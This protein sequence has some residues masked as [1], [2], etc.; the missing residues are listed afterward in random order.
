MKSSL[1]IGTRS[2][3]LALWQ[4]EF[5]RAELHARFPHLQIELYPIKTTGDKLLN[6]PLSKIGDKGLFTRDIEQ[7]LL[8]GEIDLA[9]HSLKDLPTQLPDG[10]TIAAVTAREATHDVLI[11]NA[12]YTIDTLP[13]A[14]CVATGSL[15]RRAQLLARRPD[16]RIAEMRGNLHTRLRKFDECN[17]L[18]LHHPAHLDAMVL[19]FAGVHRLGLDHRISEHISL[20]LLLPAVGQGTL[21][22]ETRHDDSETLALVRPLN[23]MPTFLCITAERSFL[24]YLEGGCQIPI[25]ALAT[26]QGATLSLSAF[27]GALNGQP[28][29][30]NQLSEVGFLEPLSSQVARAEALGVHLAEQMLAA[31]GRE[32]L[33]SIR[34][35]SSQH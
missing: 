4:A 17:A 2:S 15:R 9:V 35:S 20:N 8:S 7:A 13:P 3:P 11:S 23:D 12:G 25:G 19:A 33:S 24:R 34:A 27:I 1:L 16:L 29:V 32:I 26:L 6:S 14:A 31:G 5:V 28:F 30:R 22:L 18:P 10:L 21:A